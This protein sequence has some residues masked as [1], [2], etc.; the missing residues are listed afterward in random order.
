MQQ[1][2]RLARVFSSPAVLVTAVW[3]AMLITVAVGPIDYPGQPSLAAIALLVVGISLF[4]LAQPAGA[5]CCRIWLDGRGQA[6]APGTDQLN[7]VVTI[8]SCAG[9][10]G[11]GLIA[12]DRLVLSGV[13]NGVYAELLRCAPD[14]VDIISINRTPLLYLGYVLFSFGFA[15]LVLF[16]LRGE[17]IR[18]WPAVLSQLSI[19]SPIGYATLYA[20]R[21]AILYFIVLTLAA[22]LVR[23]AQRRPA[24]PQGHHLLLKMT[25]VVLL[26]G[27]YSSAVWS[28]RQSFCIQMSGVVRELQQRMQERDAE[29]A[30]ARE[31]RQAAIAR[32]SSET[33]QPPASKPSDSKSS[34]S[35]SSGSQSS[36]ASGPASGK[37]TG[38]DRR[39]EGPRQGESPAGARPGTAPVDSINAA[40]IGQMIAA[41]ESRRPDFQSDAVANLLAT[42]DQAWHVRPRSYV[43]SALKSGQISPQTAVSFLSTYFYLTHGVRILD[44]TWRERDRFSLHWGV[45]EIG[46][47]SP[48][49][50]VF[51]PENGELFALKSE[52]LSAKIHGFFPTAW[53]AIYIDFGM[54]GAVIYILIW[55]FAAGWSAF[56]T[57]NSGLLTP[58]LLLTFVLAS[59]MLSPA[60]GP[61]GIT[62]SALVLISIIIVGLATDLGGRTPQPPI[63]ALG[64]NPAGRTA[65]S[66]IRHA[67][68]CR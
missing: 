25:V 24:L 6:P 49:L 28:R 17:E 65:G 29:Q 23:L 55:G 48:I 42:M 13:N 38:G 18:G 34:M 16:L 53:A 43:I 68:R 40:D 8:F 27:V 32:E 1:L 10:A 33:A 19:V 7:L 44:T 47:L 20:G 63:E 50:R 52:L 14:L 31:Q 41:G 12:F 3:C 37:S 56:G 54:V 39:G 62:N 22:M 51:F 11:I 58:P 26:F 64:E 61:L 2:A 15:S 4:I 35:Q 60:Q 46:V 9:I 36:T 45:Y 66:F 57:R 67:R 59:I 5:W 30:K 21:M